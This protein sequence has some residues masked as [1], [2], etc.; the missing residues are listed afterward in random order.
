[1][2][3]EARRGTSAAAASKFAAGAEPITSTGTSATPNAGPVA[4][5]GATAATMSSA[6]TH[7]FGSIELDPVK[8]ALQ[9]STIAT[10]IVNLFS[11]R[12]GTKLRIKVDI[13][14]EDVNGFDTDT[15]RAVR[16]NAR[17]LALKQSEFD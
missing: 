12:P 13:E 11:R 9:Y 5:T 14:A 4:G 6:P 7:Y 17:T 16:E 3:Y 2:A 8:G 1:G 10:E 15:V